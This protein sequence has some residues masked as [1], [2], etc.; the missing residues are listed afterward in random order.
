MGLRAQPS[1][2][3]EDPEEQLAQRRNV[4]ALPMLSPLPPVAP[5]H[6]GDTAVTASHLLV[7]RMN[8]PTPKES[9]SLGH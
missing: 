6:S 1:G 5:R 7:P 4:P 3:G 2:D 9:S 8:Q